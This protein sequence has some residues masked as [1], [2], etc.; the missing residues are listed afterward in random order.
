MSREQQEDG[1]READELRD[2]DNWETV[3]SGR[4]PTA[5]REK[6]PEKSRPA[7]APL[8]EILVPCRFFAAGWC[9]KGSKCRFYHSHDSPPPLSASSATSSSSSSA[10]RILQ[11]PNLALAPQP[12]PQPPSVWTRNDISADVNEPQEDDDFPEDDETESPWYGEGVYYYGGVAPEESTWP[13]VYDLSPDSYLSALD[14]RAG[15]TSSTATTL[16]GDQSSDQSRKI[17]HFYAE[18]TCRFGS[19]CRNE[20]G[21]ECPICL[22]KCLPRDPIRQQVHMNEC[23]P[24]SE[25]DLDL[26]GMVECGICYENPCAR[27]ERFGILN[28]CEHV[29]CL[30]CI[31]S[32]RGTDGPGKT[33]IRG[34]PIC[35]VESHFVVPSDHFVTDGEEKPL[36]IDEY[37][38]NMKQIPC[39]HFDQGRGS[40]PFGSSCFYAHLNADGTPYKYE[41]LRTFLD[42]D[43]IM[44]AVKQVRLSDFLNI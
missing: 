22:K 29:F 38:T 12:Q 40:C 43:G 42:S 8:P 14:P 13:D 30:S 37:K 25:R 15:A 21:E 23:L 3:R 39:K 1:G 44:N 19:F 36:L 32:W 11:P 28:N 33:A 20:H 34:C 10:V 27:K 41:K 18:G 4:R 5:V 17:C 26:S 6:P 9:N 31:R 2:E 7:E 16:G 35:R 24:P